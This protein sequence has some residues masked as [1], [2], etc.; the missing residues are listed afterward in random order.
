MMRQLLHKTLKIFAW[1][2]GGL[3]LLFLLISY[4]KDPERITY[5]V[6]LSKYY[7]EELGLP[8]RDVFVAV[9]D[10][11]KVKKLR[12]IAYWPM[13]EPERGSFDFADLDWE[14]SEA[15]KRNAG[16]I[17]VVGRRVPRWPECHT[18]R[19]A[20]GLS[21]DEQ[22]AELPLYLPTLL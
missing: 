21:W 8:W 3:I 13:V 6:T 7:A 20:Q 19:W 15:K 12:L 11:L 18:P 4:G 9:L 16:V 10:E 14:L 2:L 22:K 17:L 1:F 5:G